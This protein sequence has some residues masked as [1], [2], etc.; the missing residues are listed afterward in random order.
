MRAPTTSGPRHVLVW[1][2]AVGY[3]GFVAFVVFWPS[4]VDKP[5]AGMLDRVIAELHE[6]G[7]PAFVDY[8]FIEFSA[9]VALFIPIGILFGLALPMTWWL[10]MFLL[11]PALSGAIEL[12][13]RELLAERY[14]TLSDLIA[15][16]T[17]ATVGV[18]LALLLRAIV[19]QRDDRVRERYDYERAAA[20]RVTV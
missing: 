10:A 11:G 17:G 5:V 9:N 8:E 6:R 2:L 20:A 1:L 18:L 16:S 3:G 19:A 14:A 7:V 13:Q 12:I 15:N 4:P